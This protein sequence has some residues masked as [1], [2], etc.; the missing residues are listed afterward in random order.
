MALTVTV[1]GKD[2]AVD[3]G[4]DGWF[5]ADDAN[6]KR[7]K[8]E[9]L[10]SLKVKLAQATK[11][12]SIPYVHYSEAWNTGEVTITRGEFTGLH[13]D[14]QRLLARESGKAIQFREGQLGGF[15]TD[16]DNDESLAL[17]MLAESAQAAK[18]A[19]KKFLADHALRGVRES[20]SKAL[21]D[22]E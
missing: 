22:G 20:I 6:D 13:S 21:E 8:S 17:R 16:L 1:K 11:K 19:L 12:V 2:Y 3:V 18:Q 10:A 14:G 7:V 9:T 4:G 5:Y 15:L